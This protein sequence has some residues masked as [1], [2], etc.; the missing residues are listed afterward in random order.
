MSPSMR[1]NETG[2]ITIMVALMLLVLLTVTAFSMSRNSMRELIVTGTLRQ[3]ADARNNADTGCEWALYWVGPSTTR[4]L[5]VA[6]TGAEQMV[7]QSAQLQGNT[8]NQGDWITINGDGYADMKDPSFLHGT[9]KFD[10]DVMYMGKID[11]DPFSQTEI[12]AAS[13][14]QPDLFS[15]RTTSTTSY[16]GG[17]TFVHKREV[18]S[19]V[20]VRSM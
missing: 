2:G 5:P 7:N 20:P 6:G 1:R 3:A 15:I 12:K 11:I 4:P 18:W 9:R 16:T 8:L 19:T 10:L 14:V 17:P 13:Q